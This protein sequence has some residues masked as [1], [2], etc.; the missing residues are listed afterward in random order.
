[1]Y[2]V[3]QTLREKQLY[4][5]LS[6]SEFRLN[7][8]VFLGHVIF[9]DGIL[10][11]PKK[12]EVVINWERPTNVTEV[13]SLLGL[14]V[15]YRLFIQGFSTISMSLTQLIRKEVKFEWTDRC[16]KSFQELKNK[17]VL[18]LMLTIPSGHGRFVIYNDASH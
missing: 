9:S 15:Y 18:A 2:V 11:D 14:S 3:L 13:Q 16:E 12:V 4:G 17:L 7:S 5:K 8:V 10:V 1:M 6:K